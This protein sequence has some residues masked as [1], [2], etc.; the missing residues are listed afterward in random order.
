MSHRC[1]CSVAPWGHCCLLASPKRGQNCRTCSGDCGP[2]WHGQ[3]S[4]RAS[5]SRH[6]RQCP[7]LVGTGGSVQPKDGRWRS[8]AAAQGGGLCPCGFLRRGG[9]SVN[10]NPNTFDAQSVSSAVLAV[11]VH[12]CRFLSG[13]TALPLFAL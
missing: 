13:P 2:V 1:S 12:D 3:P 5:P 11:R 8:A 10:V 6:R 4:V 7:A 9:L